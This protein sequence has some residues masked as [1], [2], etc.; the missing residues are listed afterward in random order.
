MEKVKGDLADKESNL[1]LQQHKNL[2][3][4]LRLLMF[5]QSNLLGTQ[6]LLTNV[7]S[8]T[9]AVADLRGIVFEIF[10]PLEKILRLLLLQFIIGL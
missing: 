2:L 7:H 9:K 5:Y 8:I 10:P 3:G 4:N 1:K 6:R